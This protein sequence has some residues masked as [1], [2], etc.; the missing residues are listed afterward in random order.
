MLGLS[1]PT[2][3]SLQ[4]M[5]AS[6]THGLLSLPKWSNC[7]ARTLCLS[8][9]RASSGYALKTNVLQMTLA[10]GDVPVQEVP[11]GLGDIGMI[12]LVWSARN[13]QSLS[14][15]RMHGG[16]CSMSRMLRPR[17]SHCT[18]SWTLYSRRLS[19]WLQ[20]DLDHERGRLRS[21]RHARDVKCAT[22][23]RLK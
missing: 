6:F 9:R 16:A 23:I 18:P 8:S 7:F 17:Q 11:P 14:T 10:G 1:M 15:W 19:M 22:T 3:M 2:A 20:A 21:P 12:T 5:G 13:P 4:H